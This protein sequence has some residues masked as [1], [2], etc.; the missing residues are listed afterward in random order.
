MPPPDKNTHYDESAARFKELEEA[1]QKAASAAAEDA[2]DEGK[3]DPDG[4]EVVANEGSNDEGDQT[5]CAD[6]QTIVCSCSTFHLSKS[7]K[8]TKPSSYPENLICRQLPH[9]G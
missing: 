8:K 7:G 4:I 5:V 3:L 6:D 1:G 2:R 9:L